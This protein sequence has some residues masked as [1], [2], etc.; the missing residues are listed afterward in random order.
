ME[1]K[2]INTADFEPWT[3]GVWPQSGCDDLKAPVCFR[4]DGSS[5]SRGERGE[6]KQLWRSRSLTRPAE[7]FRGLSHYLWWCVKTCSKTL[8]TRLRLSTLSRS[9][10]WVNWANFIFFLNSQA[11]FFQ[12]LIFPK[13]FWFLIWKWSQS[14]FFFLWFDHFNRPES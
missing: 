10:C 2:R 12:T 11:F 7:V 9:S 13:W 14:F 5:R 3:D 4:S 8:P 1:V 6:E